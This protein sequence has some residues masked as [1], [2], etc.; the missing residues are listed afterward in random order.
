MAEK[1]VKGRKRHIVT[2]ICGNILAVVV[3]AANIHDT[4]GGCRVFGEAL[5]KYPSIKGVSADEGYRKTFEQFVATIMRKTEIVPKLDSGWSILP[6]RWRVERTFSWLNHSRR[7]SKDYEIT[8]CAAKSLVL[9]SHI[10][11]LL[12]RCS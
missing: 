12:K 5:W 8:T 10:H 7:L 2:D 11:T 4:V 6:K 9:I 1:K 3:H